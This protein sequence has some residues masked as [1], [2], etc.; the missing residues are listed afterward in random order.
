MS[1]AGT[2]GP[3]RGSSRGARELLMVFCDV[4]GAGLRA[5]GQVGWQG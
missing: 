5:T 2:G 1:S 4:A 3:G